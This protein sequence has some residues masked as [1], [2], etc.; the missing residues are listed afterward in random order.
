MAEAAKILADS[1][2]S[3]RLL[4]CV[5][6]EVTREAASRAAAQLGWAD[7]V[8]RP[9]GIA[10]AVNAIDRAK[11]PRLVLVDLAD[12]ADPATA[13]SQVITR[14]GGATRVIAIGTVNDV[15]LFRQLAAEGVADYLVKPVS[16][17]LL[18]EAFRRALSDE[19]G[20]E[21]KSRSRIFAFLGTR[22]GVGT[23]TLAL[24]TAWILAHEH[25]L[26][27]AVIDLDLHFGNLALTLDLEPGRGLRQALERPERTDGLLLA[28]AMVKASDELPILSAE[29]PLEDMLRFDPAAA[30][31]VLTALGQDYECLVVDIPRSLDGAS[32]QVLG[33]AESAVIATD[34]SLTALRDALRL[35]DLSKALGC[36]STPIFIGSQIGAQHRGE[37]GR[38]EFER[39]LGTALDF[40]VPFDAKAA[41]AMAHAAKALP[42]SASGSKPAAEMR[43]LA[44]RLVGGEE[45]KARTG[46]RKWLG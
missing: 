23:T 27:T 24:G 7:V 18:C 9:G 12:A 41:K 42:A 6:D 29:E 5:A 13:V 40:A 19:V 11:P 4:A 37:I 30:T 15:A 45:K 36:R 33:A 25:H 22:G 38:A 21:V 20:S 14:C 34:L 1:R 35:A 28:S 31:A 43:R 16:S 26:K 10:A 8:L 44:A 3:I 17:E 2:D 39:G 32:R 46:L